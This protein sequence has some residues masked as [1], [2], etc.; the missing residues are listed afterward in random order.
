MDRWLLLNFLGEMMKIDRV[1]NNN[2]V[3]VIT[4]NGNES[5]ALGNGIGWGKRKATSS[6]SLILKAIF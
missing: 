2:A 5:V 4:D 1:L 3:L 6:K